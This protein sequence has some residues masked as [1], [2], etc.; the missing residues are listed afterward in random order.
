MWLVL[1]LSFALWS[2]ITIGLIKH[3][4]KK[5]EPRALAFLLSAITIPFMV[6]LLFLTGGIPKT[7]PA[8]YGLIIA[9]SILD[10]VAFLAYFIAISKSPISLLGPLAS[11]GP[12]ITTIV[13]IFALGEIP[14]PLKFFGVVLI[15]I[16]AYAL[17]IKDI[18]QGIFTPFQKLFKSEGVK[19]FLIATLIWGLTPIL[20]KKAILATNPDTPFFP[21]VVGL[22]LSTL[23]LFPFA[24]KQTGN[25]IKEA[26][27]NRKVIILY[28][29]V[30]SLAQFAIYAAFAMAPV[31]YVSSIMRLS[32]LFTV[33]IGGVFLK[34]H[35]VR[36][37][38]VGG[39]IM[40]I[41]ALLLATQ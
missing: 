15:V 9:S 21:A 1:A 26:Y 38:L 23:F 8:F 39:A 31:G 12:I 7:T 17:N 2:A 3:L 32:S 27:Q 34:E 16:G 19:L 37:R 14:T 29:S 11:F 28:G 20:Q 4:S 10:T 36:E 18:K 13:A 33:V 24:Y 5:I 22:I 41:G 40:V 35:H 6:V 25:L 30:G